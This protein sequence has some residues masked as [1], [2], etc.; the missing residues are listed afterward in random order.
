MASGLSNISFECDIE[1]TVAVAQYCKADASGV[2]ATN[3]VIDVV[4]GL[5]CYGGLS[6]VAL[7]LLV[8][9]GLVFVLCSFRTVARD[10]RSRR[11]AT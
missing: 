9:S 7:A 2:D 8:S 1:D 6:E 3:I 10:A 5:H 11:S 4:F